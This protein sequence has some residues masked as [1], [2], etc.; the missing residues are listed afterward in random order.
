M[1]FKEFVPEF[2][3][4]SLSLVGIQ[5]HK[6]LGYRDIVIDPAKKLMIHIRSDTNYL[7]RID[8]KIVNIDVFKSNQK[9]VKPVGVLGVWL[10]VKTNKLEYNYEKLCDFRFKQQIICLDWSDELEKIVVGCDDGKLF[11]ATYTRMEPT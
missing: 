8:A 3:N 6:K 7:G 11:C 4:A 10:Q 5:G 1:K 9:V 2:T